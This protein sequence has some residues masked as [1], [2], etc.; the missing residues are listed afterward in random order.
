VKKAACGCSWLTRL[1]FFKG[2][3]EGFPKMEVLYT[4][5]IQT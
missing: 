1:H 3:S 2:R 5:I 4:Q